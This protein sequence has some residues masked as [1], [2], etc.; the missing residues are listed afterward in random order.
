MPSAVSNSD[1]SDQVRT[2]RLLFA[3]ELAKG[4]LGEDDLS[5]PEVKRATHVKGVPARGVR[6]AQQIRHK[7]G[8]LD[9][10]K[11]V[12]A[13]QQAARRAVL[14][15]RAE[16]A[17]RLL[18]RVDEF[19]HYRAWDD[20]E[21]F[22]AAA[23]ER[24]HEIMAGAGVPYLIAA[25]PRLSREPLS[26]EQLGSRPLEDGEVE[27]LR[28]IA[29]EG[30]TLGLHGLDHRTRDSSPRRHSELCGLDA[31][32]TDELLQRAMAELAGYGLPAPEVF[33]APY[34]RFDASQ[35][36]VLG[37][38]F[39]V[40]CGGP[41]SIGTVGFHR[42]PQWRGQTVYLPSYAPFYGHAGEVLAALDQAERGLAGLWTP[43]VLHWGWE[44][45]EGW[46]ELERLAARMAGLAVPWGEF[47]EAVEQS[48]ESGDPS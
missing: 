35:F 8:G 24:F 41:E 38:R 31:R 12:V 36:K 33:V 6:V 1:A 13:P 26:P 2:A 44:A 18:V 19:P 21:R 7:L 5:S 22:G 23:F 16:G 45:E 27:V 28:R 20:P 11:R 40:V 46:R 43:V 39:Q 47:L 14:R 48:R 32:E 15:D 17:P 4:V 34:N 25:L 10:E 29:G 3:A 30:V 9:Y 37:R 42:T